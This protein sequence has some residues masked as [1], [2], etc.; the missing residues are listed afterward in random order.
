MITKLLDAEEQLV[1]DEDDIIPEN[2]PSQGKEFSIINHYIV[3]YQQV[4]L[5]QVSYKFLSNI[6]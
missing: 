2:S 3:M 5:D 4:L 1:Q 6:N